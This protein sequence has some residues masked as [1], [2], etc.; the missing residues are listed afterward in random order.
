MNKPKIILIGGG[1][2]CKSCIDVI[3]QEDKYQIEGIIDVPEKFGNKI[4]TY[5]VIGNDNDIPMYA[6][7]GRNFLIT[8]GHLGNPTLRKKLFNLVKNNRGLLPVIISPIAYVSKHANI[9]EGTIIMH[10]ALIN[11]NAEIGKNCIINTN[12]LIEH[13]AIIEDNTHISTGAIINGSV[14]I[15]CES[16]IGSGAVTRENINIE[17]RSF[18]KANSIVKQ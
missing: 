7:Q 5:K 2:H 12:A 9:G 6:Q 18:I 4:F 16:F 17:A 1:G 10:N 11:A 3:E 14:K 8:V 15:G 13:D